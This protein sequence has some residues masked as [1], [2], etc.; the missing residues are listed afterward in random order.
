MPLAL[1]GKEGEAINELRRDDST[2][3][4]APTAE[5]RMRPEIA[6]RFRATISDLPVADR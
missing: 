2:P 3:T 6:V 1:S 5:T 4:T